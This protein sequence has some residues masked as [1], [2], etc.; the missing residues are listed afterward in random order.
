[1]FFTASKS[2]VKQVNYKFAASRAYILSQNQDIGH[3]IKK[4]QYYFTILGIKTLC[5]DGRNR[6]VDTRIFSP[7]LYRLS[8]ITVKEAQK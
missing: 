4:A 8:Y 3:T 7:L 5:G 1:M 6:T 2:T